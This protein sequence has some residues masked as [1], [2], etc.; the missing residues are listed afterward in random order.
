M[1]SVGVVSSVVAS[2]AVVSGV[3]TSGSVVSG[4]VTSGADVLGALSA[5]VV[6]VSDVVS[7][8]PPQ[9]APTMAKL[10]TMA[11]KRRCARMGSP[12]LL[13]CSARSETGRATRRV[14]ALTT[15]SLIGPRCKILAY[16][17]TPCGGGLE[18]AREA[19]LRI[20]LRDVAQRS[21]VSEATVSRVI[22]GK[23]GVSAETRASVLAV[24]AE[25][26]YQPPGLDAPTRIGLVG[27]IVPELDNPIFPLFAQSI[28]ARLLTR[29]Y[30]SVLCCAGRIGAKEEDYVPTLLD[31]RV[32]GMVFVSGRHSIVDGDHTIYRSLLDRHLPLVF[33]NGAADQI[34][35]P[36]VGTDEAAAAS[37]AVEHLARL[38]HRRI[39]FLT[40]SF[41]H[42]CVGRRYA[43]YRDT[44]DRLGL[45]DDPELVMRSTFTVAGGQA[46]A[47]Q[48]LNAGATAIITGND[49]MALGVI[50]AVRQAGLEVPADVS[51]IGYDDT[52]LIS[53]TDPPLTTVRQHVGVISD[54]AVEVLM[55]Q[56]EGRSLEA[57][58]YLVRPDL[59]V[60]GSTGP[61]TATV[62]RR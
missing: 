4:V 19:E 51:V 61:L 47:P 52:E 1:V 31:R 13:R 36:S 50:R 5:T 60:R 46:A 18:C 59:I 29:G 27:L 38:G 62:G 15:I 40:G 45:D 12:P 3:V 34:A 23:A 49:L 42:V 43:G 17:F 25:L 10:A 11:I 58:E 39:G 37:I 54:H 26:G 20:R 32:A 6:V 8:S 14:A 21:N 35:V 53:F 44:I 22:N 55:S 9:A 41:S 57:S 7:S 30:V 48:L 16:S 56:I 33:V 24:L 2:G 28:E